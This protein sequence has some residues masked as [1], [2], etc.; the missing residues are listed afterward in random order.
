MMSGES[1]AFGGNAYLCF[2]RKVAS[3]VICSKK[4]VLLYLQ[5]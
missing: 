2:V 5:S 3:R 1:C 4:F